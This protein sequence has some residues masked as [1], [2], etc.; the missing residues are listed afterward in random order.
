[1]RTAQAT[2]ARLRWWDHLAINIYALGLSISAGVITPVLLPYLVALFVAQEQKNSY[3]ATVRVM[4][5]AVAMLVQPLA[6]MLSDRSTHPWGR[7]RPFIAAG[8]LLD[9]VFLI[10]IG[11]SPLLIGSPLDGS[12]QARLGFSSAYGLLLLGIILLQASSNVAQGAFQGL[13]PDLVPHQ[14]RG[15]S[16]GVKSVMELLRRC[17]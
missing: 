15:L 10:L 4:G 3:L 1:M 11:A 14:Q 8:T 16:S 5:L 6:G 17:W 9:L 13:M 12:I 7:R 2:S